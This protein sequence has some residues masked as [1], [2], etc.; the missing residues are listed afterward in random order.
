MV[1]VLVRQSFFNITS[2]LPI[3]IRFRAYRLRPECPRIGSACGGVPL[4]CDFLNE[5]LVSL[6]AQIQGVTMIPIAQL[7]RRKQQ[8]KQKEQRE[9][10]TQNKRQKLNS[11]SEQIADLEKAVSDDSDSNS[12]SDSDSSDVAGQDENLIVETDELGNV[13]RIGTSIDKETLIEPLPARYLPARNCSKSNDK[14][15][16]DPNR[17]SK[18]RFQDASRPN[19]NPNPNGLSKTIVEMLRNYEPASLEKQ[20]HSFVQDL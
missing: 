2:Q 8:Q 7:L 6:S 10:D 13:I 15:L 16:S 20:L 19:P 3:T 9:S 12:D 1:S 17:A 18:V 5:N 14:V 11:I 4:D